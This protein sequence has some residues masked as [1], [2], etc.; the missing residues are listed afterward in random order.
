M[1]VNLILAAAVV[2]I[3]VAIS[4]LYL[5][6]GR[7]PGWKPR[8][9]MEW[10]GSVLSV[11][12]IVASMALIVVGLRVSQEPV[13]VLAVGGVADDPSE[14][15]DMAVEAPAG[16]FVFTRVS[17]GMPA[18]LEELRGKVVLLNFWGTWCAPCISEIPEL[19]RLQED[20]ED[21]GLVVL[22]VSDE[23][24]ALMSQFT[25]N[26]PLK[27]LSAQ[28]PMG[29]RLPNPFSSAFTIRPQTFVIDREGIV[30]R[31]IIG[32]RSYAIFERFVEP[33]L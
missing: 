9:A 24:P 4:F 28:V 30:H 18:S 20:Y 29:T 23:D 13:Q 12:L 21:E 25:A 31:H 8:D 7:R 33:H 16:D 19:N 11:A 3:A 10:I 27:T 26:F 22:S 14:I 15:I 6:L 2:M 17:D 1:D 5:L 32:A